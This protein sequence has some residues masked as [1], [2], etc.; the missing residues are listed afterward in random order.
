MLDSLYIKNFRLF[1]ELTIEQLGRVNLIV[2]RNNT[3][4]S[5]LLEAIQIY[6]SNASDSV[7]NEIFERREENIEPLSE[8]DIEGHYFSPL[9][10]LFY[11]YSFPMPET[12]EDIMVIGSYKQLQ[13]RLTT[14][15]GV[16]DNDD[17][18]GTSWTEFLK[19]GKL[20]KLF[21]ERDWYLHPHY[22]KSKEKLKT[23]VVRF[24]PTHY[25][26]KVKVSALWN[27]INLTDKQPIIVKGLQVIEPKIQNIALTVSNNPIPI[28]RLSGYSEPRPLKSMGDG[29]ARAFHLM[30]TLV[31][32]R[33]GFLLID[34]FE[35]G[36]HYTVQPKV[37]ELIFKF[38]PKLNIQ[39]FVTTHSCDSV[40]AF[41]ET[42]QKN[43]TEAMLFHL[44]RSALRSDNN[45]VIAT[46]YDK[47]ELELVTFANLEVR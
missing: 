14:R 38:A 22:P 32:A 43:E 5:C 41:V 37:W 33:G 3:G 26:D 29:L 30:L 40:T 4:K 10:N 9:I 39:V 6:A 16:G 18:I 2:G 28:V 17:G 19:N 35:N 13:N 21:D 7:L 1:K 11:N 24:V 44:G 31:N 12:D 36:L 20:I 27:T 46:A 45:K 42:T 8:A 34:E 47:E 15:H 25:I 23:Q